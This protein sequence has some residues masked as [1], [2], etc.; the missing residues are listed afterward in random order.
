[1]QEN[2]IDAGGMSTCRIYASAHTHISRHQDNLLVIG[3]MCV[4]MVD[5]DLMYIGFWVTNEYVNFQAAT[6]FSRRTLDLHID[7]VAQIQFLGNSQFYDR[8]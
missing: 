5:L 7:G 4:V 1:M 6:I 8:V 3:R 2:A